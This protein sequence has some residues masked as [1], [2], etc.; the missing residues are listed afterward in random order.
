M[1]NTTGEQ[2]KLEQEATFGKISD[3]LAVPTIGNP[4]QGHRK[5]IQPRPDNK[6]L[7]DYPGNKELRDRWIT[8]WTTERTV[9]MT[10]TSQLSG[11][12]Q[13]K[14]GGE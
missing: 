2:K 13:V 10:Q 12:S 4:L 14:K 8:E 5:W 1:S 11:K 9:T 6:V 7:E 3:A